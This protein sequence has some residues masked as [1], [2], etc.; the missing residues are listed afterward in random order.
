MISFSIYKISIA[1]LILNDRF[2]VER[3]VLSIF[4]Q[5]GNKISVRRYF[6]KLI[7]IIALLILTSSRFCPTVCPQYIYLLS[8]GGYI[9]SH[10]KSLSVDVIINTH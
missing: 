6:D 7:G 4:T 8:A 10:N 3:S 5:S 9:K 2:F 1:R